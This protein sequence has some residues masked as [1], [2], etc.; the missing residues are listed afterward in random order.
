MTNKILFLNLPGQRLYVRDYFC[1]KVSKADYINAPI[2]LVM[3]SGKLNTGE[4]ELSLIDAVVEKLY[5]EICLEKITVLQPQT[6]IALT[7][8]VSLEEDRVFLKKLS[9]NFSGAI[10]VIGDY[11]LTEGK[12]FL[13]DNSHIKGVILNFVSDGIYYCLKGDETRITDMIVRHGQ[14]IIEY[15]RSN[16]LEFKIGL[17]LQA[18]F[19]KRNYRMPFIRRY[20]F[21][22]TLT[23]YACPFGCTFCIMNTFKFAQRDFDDLFLE[24]DQL[25]SLG[26]KEIFFLDQT[27]GVDKE[28]FRLI[29]NKMIEKDY[30][31]GWFGFSRVD[32]IDEELLLLMK[33]AGCHTLWFGVE[34]ASDLTLASYK[35]GYGRKDIVK[36]F[37]LAKKTGIKTLATFILG[38][39]EESRQMMEETISFARELDPDYASFN[40]AVP[41]LGT[42]LRQEAIDYGLVSESAMSMDQS[43]Q[44]IAMGTKSVGIK[45]IE[46]LRRRAI[47]SFYLRP[48]YIIRRALALRS[49]TEISSQAR[50]FYYLIKSLV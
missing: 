14:D 44:A 38:L 19:I 18:E 37:N 50:N 13:Q 43:G 26:V 6:I 31:F 21:A 36:A 2:D 49:W 34:S 4:F 42:H 16:V 29:L 25:K 12:N 39:P 9:E 22:T 11:L 23:S 10:Y 30:G 27:L 7:G 33:R 47:M 17:P 46:A 40:F 1:S 3:I 35:K 48:H 15:P 45:E 20:P 32:I 24:L 5:S 28:R 41:R 8:S